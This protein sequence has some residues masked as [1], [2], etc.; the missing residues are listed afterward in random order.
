MSR[1]S[2]PSRKEIRQV[3]R[4]LS[5]GAARRPRRQDVRQVARQAAAGAARGAMRGGT[6]GAARGAAQ[7]VARQG[8]LR[9]AAS[10]AGLW[11]AVV[12][13]FIGVS[14]MA[15]PLF[16]TIL[17]AGGGGAVAATST[18]CGPTLISAD[19]S[20]TILG[21]SSL[22]AAQI[23]SWWQ[24]VHGSSMPIGVDP[25]I[26]ISWWI[27][28]GTTEGV[29]GDLA[30]AQ[31]I[32]ETGAFTNNDS[33][34][35]NNFAGIGHPDG[36]AHGIPFSSPEVGVVADLQLLKEVATGTNAGPFS[37]AK[38]AP[39]WG[40]RPAATWYLLGNQG[41]G[42]T[43][44]WASAAAADYWKGISGVYTAMGGVLAPGP[45][46]LVSANPT[47]ATT[48]TVPPLASL[49]CATLASS[50]GLPAG[51][52]LGP[53][54][55]FLAAQ[56]GKPYQFGGAGPDSWDCS[57]LTMVAYAQV[58][59]QLPH[60]AAAQYQVTGATM[61]PLDQLQPGDLV[62]FEPGI[63]HVGI[64]VGGGQ[65]I[66]APHTGAFVEKVPLWTSQYQGASRPA[67]AARPPVAA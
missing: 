22:T 55:A 33:I 12:A 11:V 44:Y 4:R 51:G 43:G 63:G 57:G 32:F 64:Y 49:G 30:F 42:D 14:M 17:F 31:A 54:W 19:G 50:A 25:A 1:P 24:R 8:R 65:M 6:G 48:T 46:T 5:N 41:N 56:M 3:R 2:R 34:Q 66:D 7:S 58:G 52:S 29:R 10:H 9:E 16:I 67:A 20:P 38:V 37:E 39:N 18:S 27:D 61:I 47:A 35:Y 40:G 23:T 62:F 36:A 53:L 15:G 13:I 21:P 28:H 59:I 26:F 60:N 45:A